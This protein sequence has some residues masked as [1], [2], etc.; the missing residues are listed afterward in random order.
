MK[1]SVGIILL[2]VALSLLQV[3]FL[4]HFP[5][6]GVVFNGTGILLVLWAF[7]ESP[8]SFLSIFGA[9]AGGATLDVFSATFFG[10]W[11]LLFFFGVLFVK[12]IVRNYVR[13][14]L[15]PSF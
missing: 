10:F 5:L 9:I 7:G 1:S 12:Y 11:I 15:F 4:P 13:L 14:P 8:T 2:F 6:W 3:S